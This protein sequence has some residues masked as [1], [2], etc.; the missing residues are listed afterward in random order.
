MDFTN[1]KAGNGFINQQDVFNRLVDFRYPD[2]SLVLLRCGDFSSVG[3]II[4]DKTYPL[5]RVYTGNRDLY[6]YIRDMVKETAEKLQSRFEADEWKK[7]ETWTSEEAL[8]ALE[9]RTRRE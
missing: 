5:F 3:V 7:N 4:D 2:A 8:E 9:E 6:L 1:L